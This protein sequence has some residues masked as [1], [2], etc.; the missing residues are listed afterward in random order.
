[1]R[2]TLLIMLLVGTPCMAQSLR[3]SCKEAYNS[4]GTSWSVALT[5]APT[6]GDLVMVAVSDGHASGQT[7]TV[8]DANSHSYTLTPQSPATPDANVA[9]FSMGYILSAS[10]A[11]A[12]I[13]VTWGTA[14]AG[15]VR[16]CDINPAGKTAAFDVGADGTQTLSGT[17][18][19]GVSISPSA[20]G[21]WV[22]AVAG[23]DNGN[24]TN[25]TS[26]SSQGVWTG[27]A[28]ED[29]T[30]GDNDEYIASSSGSGI[31]VNF[32]D[33]VSGDD[34]AAILGA[35]SFSGGST[36]PPCMPLLHAPC[37][38]NG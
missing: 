15:D 13:D 5:S 38:P 21:E 7:P 26:G 9:T 36:P 33:S 2:K 23:G 19:N 29:S 31:A 10:S 17:T 22:W 16:V 14:T 35:F 24:L 20:N 11:S 32:T 37:G 4:S 25:P 18:F 28:G 3:Q 8:K 30:T 12:T 27:G 1:M 34:C 6:N